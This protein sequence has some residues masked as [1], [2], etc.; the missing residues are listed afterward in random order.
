MRLVCCRPGHIK[1]G[2]FTIRDDGPRVFDSFG[3][4][5]MCYVSHDR[6]LWRRLVRMG[7][8]DAETEMS[9]V[10]WRFDFWNSNARRWFRE[11]ERQAWE[12]KRAWARA[13]WGEDAG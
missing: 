1:P 2:S 10:F 6:E 5:L 7:F 9:E 8:L 11:Q 4:W 12:R 13:K 3:A